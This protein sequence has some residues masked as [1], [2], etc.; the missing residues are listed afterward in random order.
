MSRACI[1]VVDNHPEDLRLL[2]VSLKNVGFAVTTAAN[3]RDAL[4]KV[5]ISPPDLII[6]ETTLP[7]MDGFAF[8][9]ALKEKPD[10]ADVP[11]LFLS[12]DRSVENK[13]RGLELGVDDYLTK[14]VFVKELIAR[15]RIILQRRERQRLEGRDS[16]TRFSGSLDDIGLV[17]LIQTID[18]SR[19]TG[20]L[21]LT[22]GSENGIIYFQDGDVV[23]AEV[24]RHKGVAAVYRLLTWSDGLFD[25]DFR[26]V[27]RGRAVHLATQ[28]I[29]MEGMRRLDEWGRLVEQLP[30]LDTVFMVDAGE[31]IDRLDE[32]P[33]EVN[34]IIRLTDGNRTLLEIID[35]AP[36]DDLETLKIIT[37]LS[38]YGIFVETGR[39][40]VAPARAGFAYA[41][42][43]PAVLPPPSSESSA[44]TS[45]SALSEKAEKIRARTQPSPTEGVFSGRDTVAA[46]PPP[47]AIA[48][49][50]PL[51]A[52]PAPAP[53]APRAPREVVDSPIREAP[54]SPAPVPPPSPVEFKLPPPPVPPPGA[55]FIPPPVFPAPPPPPSPE[56]EP[57]PEREIPEEPAAAP[58]SPPEP[59]PPEPPATPA[60]EPATVEAVPE[61]AA[62]AAEPV[63]EPSPPVAVPPVEAEPVSV[64]AGPS[65]AAVE[66]AAPVPEAPVPVSDSMIEVPTVE[67][68]PGLIRLAKRPPQ[69]LRILPGV[70]VP[71]A[72]AAPVAIPGWSML[73]PPPSAPAASGMA[74]PPPRTLRLG[75]P[76]APVAGMPPAPF[77]SSPSAADLDAMAERLAA[78]SPFVRSDGDGL[79]VPPPPPAFR[80]ASGETP[81]P[82]DLKREDLEP[83]AKSGPTTEPADGETGE[84][85]ADDIEVVDAEADRK[86]IIDLPG[87]GK[88]K[89]DDSERASHVPADFLEPPPRRWGGV[90]VGA[91]LALGAIAA[92]LWVVYGSG[93]TTGKSRDARSRA[94]AAEDVPGEPPDDFD[95]GV[96]APADEGTAPPEP[97]AD[98][99]MFD[100]EEAPEAWAVEEVLV[101]PVEEAGTGWDEEAGATWDDD[102][103]VPPPAEDVVVEPPPPPPA[104]GCAEARDEARG[105]W[106]ERDREGAIRRSMASF[107][108]PDDAIDLARQ[109]AQWVSET[110]PLYRNAELTG[111]LLDAL[112]PV[113]EANPN[114]G[115]L[116]F[117]YV[118]LLY[119]NGRRE[120]ADAAKARCGE[121]RPATEYSRSCRYLPQ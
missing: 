8:L 65:P 13:V 106:R 62:V 17:D 9:K 24:G 105:L 79:S 19:K 121:I 15:L 89:P 115:T 108:C 54:P 87:G 96:V 100:A 20:A 45:L 55:V 40:S 3:G 57:R 18:M 25:V 98:A 1:L 117:F 86:V 71:G 47:E 77:P 22:R 10:W 114:D 51:P 35:A 113:A 2:E 56:P 81:A 66:L 90:V 80:L 11:F 110:P 88:R 14:P 37:Q 39:R 58:P 64:D 31:L 50:P 28:E 119:R 36:F 118:D 107:G 41:K 112:A 97:A 23:D 12:E 93:P 102:A 63:A 91:L 52:R 116:W 103:V 67:G 109:A 72:P 84:S 7:E 92:G 120:A 111:A 26:P 95:A 78:Q 44:L 16:K 43:V 101:Q 34:A 94:S 6:S 76:A 70:P 29:L 99:W 21:R 30:P 69:T 46:P 42:E 85:D 74:K 82:G 33:D 60:P 38:F 5:E 53:R 27:R 68:K 75:P 83:E 49:A 59:G 4:G 61:P 32:I 73:P 104:G 48:A